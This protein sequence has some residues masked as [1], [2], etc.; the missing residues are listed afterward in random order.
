M[1]DGRFER[2]PQA[3]E[4]IEI[5]IIMILGGGYP[6]RDRSLSQ[7]QR[8]AIFTRDGRVCRLCGAPATEID[9]INGSSSD[10][11]NLQAVCGSCNIA[12][13][14]SNT[15]PA[16]TEE[17]AEGNTIMARIR[18]KHPARLCDDETK[19][20]KIWREISANQKGRKC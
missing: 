3:R 4:A 5:R 14:K 8:E 19:W 10:P 15:R 17:E 7:K 11:D 2:D 6:A 20:D 13:A 12:K 1:K 16:T 9:H 18:A